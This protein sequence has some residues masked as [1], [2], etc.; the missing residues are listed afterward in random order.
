[1]SAIR[2]SI[3]RRRTAEFA[4]QGVS[5]RNTSIPFMLLTTAI[6][7]SGIAFA[8]RPV[9]KRADADYVVSGTVTGVYS[10]DSEGYSNYIIEIKVDQVEKGAVNKSDFFRAFCYRRKPGKG[11]LQFDTD[12][13]N[14]VPKEGQR[15]KAFVTKGYGWNEGI[16][17]DWVDILDGSKPNAQSPARG[18][19]VATPVPPGNP[20]GNQ[21]VSK[22]LASAQSS[23]SK[24]DWDAVVSTTSEA[25]RIQPANV[26]ALTLRGNAWTQKHQFDKALADYN[27][28]VRIQPNV[29][30]LVLRGGAHLLKKEWDAALGDCCK[31]I[32]MDPTF[33]LAYFYRGSVHLQKGENSEAIG[34][35]TQALRLAPDDA[36]CYSARAQAYH[37][38]A[39]FNLTKDHE[40]AANDFQS[41]LSDYRQIIRLNAQDASA[42][43]QLAWLQA[44]CP[45]DQVRDGKAAVANA[46]QACELAN[47]KSSGYLDTLA[48]AYA[49]AGD[50]EQAITW[51][52]GAIDLAAPPQKARMQ[53]R[54]KLYE[55]REPYRERPA[56]ADAGS[57]FEVN[58]VWSDNE[59]TLTVT[60]RKDDTFQATFEHRGTSDHPGFQRQIRGTMKGNQV[61]WLAKDVRPIKGG[62]GSDNSGMIKSH[63]GSYRIEFTWGTGTDGKSGGSFTLYL[64]GNN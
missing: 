56:V 51:Q 48:A 44:T 28:L 19:G 25:L 10:R 4:R 60:E 14:T 18:S 13:H 64:E 1:M 52:Y 12:G 58:S 32:E 42:L 16:Y 27:D 47:Y 22:L 54:A 35:L 8:D 17:P 57:P 2:A 61:Q 9:E 36:A 33:A 39:Y 46:L 34:D 62:A 38:R 49:E 24:N 6:L 23:L 30:N 41:A 50:F 31:A 21:Q 26:E 37:G 55:K 63:Y 15:I 43:N 11:G 59:R 5:M 3:A 40:S 20:K 7:H 53:E 29:A 45:V